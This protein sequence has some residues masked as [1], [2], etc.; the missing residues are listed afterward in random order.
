MRENYR[1]QLESL[2]RELIAMGS[3]C[4]S[5]IDICINVIS[6]SESVPEEIKVLEGE[7]N[8]KER[9]LE[10]LCIKILLQQQ[11]VASDLR[12]ISAALKMVTD[13]ERIGDNA[14]DIAEVA[15]Y[16]GSL[17][18]KERKVFDDLSGAVRH[19]VHN[20]IDAFVRRD[21]ELAKET[22]EYDNVVDSLFVRVK[23]SVI[24]SIDR[25]SADGE[26]I[27]DLLMCAKYFE[28]IGDHAVNVARWAIFAK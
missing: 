7:I 14:V 28:R 26:S 3:L 1:K 9:E 16:I 17:S 18:E 24:E 21:A 25:E 2:S 20:A 8:S 13:L 22:I 23:H 4:E 5:A 19:I 11:P 10:N 6:R 12:F 15:V 27:I